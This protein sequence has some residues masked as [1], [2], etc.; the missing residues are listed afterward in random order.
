MRVDVR[1]KEKMQFKARAEGSG[2]GIFI[3]G[4]GEPGEEVLGPRPMEVMLM[5][6]GGCTGIDILSILRKMRLEFSEF[7]IEIEAQRASDHPKVFTEI[8]LFYRIKGDNIAPEA[9]ERAIRLSQEKYCSASQSLKAP[10]R[11]R[12]EINGV[13]YEPQGGR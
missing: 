2:G 11:F 6:V 13:V 7:W 8:T 4:G 3:D 1:W 9:M 5:S 12:Y 10:I